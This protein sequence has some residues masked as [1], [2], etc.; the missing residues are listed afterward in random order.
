MPELLKPFVP[1]T[2]EAKKP[3]IKLED[4]KVDVQT[5]SHTP[6]EAETKASTLGWMP[7][8]KW[9]E[10]GHDAS[11][12]KP[13]KVFL[14]HGDMIGKI[15]SQSRDIDEM[16][17]A[18]TFANAQNT[19]VFEKGYQQA[20]TELREQKR[21][22]LAAG[23]LVKADEIDERIDLTKEQLQNVRNQNAAVARAIPKTPTVDP[24][25]IDWVAR[26]SWYN[27]DK[28]LAKFA[29]SMAVTYIEEN[30]GNVTAQQVREY[31][32][33]EV[34]KEFPDRAG[35][36]RPKAAPSPD[37]ESRRPASSNASSG[38]LD[39]KLSRAKS[40]MTDE[41]RSIMKTIIKSTGMTEKKYLEL[42]SS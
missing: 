29:D 10:A 8:E 40:D 7:E 17:K 5:E 6:T 18:L 9:V 13:A 24:E 16:K 27:T 2:P 28:T 42:Y 20:I 35:T 37:G 31:V 39:S 19:Q 15:R 21:A 14:E 30:R 1:A 3:E 4:K 23:D 26:N 11:D 25:H 41:Q 36:A 33:R 32:E 38:S 12:W 34:K 22:A